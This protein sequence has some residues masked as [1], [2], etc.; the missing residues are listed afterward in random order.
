MA[1]LAVAPG[2]AQT[3]AVVFQAQFSPQALP[4]N[5]KLSLTGDRVTSFFALIRPTNCAAPADWATDSDNVFTVELPASADVEL[6]AGAFSFQGTAPSTYY[7]TANAQY[8]GTFSVSGTVNPAHTVVT[9]TVTLTGA[10]DQ[11]VSG[12]S[13]SY[14]FIAVPNVSTTSLRR[15]DRTA[16]QGHNI[17]F[18]DAAGSITNLEL[19]AAMRCGGSV[20]SALFDG[21]GV[22]LT[23]RTAP[24]G[25]FT[26]QGYVLDGYQDVVSLTIT[27][28]V[29][30]RHASG[31]IIVAE[32]PGGFVGVG[33]A[34]CQANYRWTAAKPTP[35][36]PPAPTA[37]FQWGA[38][39]VPVGGAYRYYFAVFGLSCRSGANEVIVHVAARRS[40]LTCGRRAQYASGPLAPGRT[41]VLKAQ[42]VRVRHGRVVRRG[43]VVPTTQ[44]MPG[45]NDRWIPIAGLPGVPPS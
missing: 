42:A 7:S 41:Y 13:G 26:Y 10:H 36:G 34:P 17:S 25:R 33:N 44:P 28:E 20:D 37:F 8:A 45:P 40:V 4:G 21:R 11:I 22:H 12:C 19:A 31:R 39:R 5:S 14:S 24:G 15:P 29:S 35:P 32:P 9:G 2:L 43:F 1:V 23:V 38:I 16:Y 27:G 30:G 3:G 18:D 6:T